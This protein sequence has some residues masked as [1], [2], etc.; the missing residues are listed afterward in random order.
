MTII[1][2]ETFADVY[3]DL[4][5]SLLHDYDCITAPRDQ[6]IKELLNC[7]VVIDNP[8][9]NL[10]TNSHRSIPLKYL[11]NELKLYLSGRNDAQGFIDASAFWGKIANDDGT[12][13]SAYGYLIFNSRNKHGFSQYEWANM[14]LLKDKDSRQAI[15]HFNLPEHQYEGNKDFP[16]T[17]TGIFNI[18]DDKLNLTINIRSNDVRKGVQFDI[19]FFTLLQ[20]IMC[21][22][23]KKRYPNLTI[24]T[25]THIANSMHIY[26]ADFDLAQA[27]IDGTFTPGGIPLAGSDDIIMSPVYYKGLSDMDNFDQHINKDFYTWIQSI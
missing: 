17:L 11:K 12:I 2:G 3:K 19:P 26:E 13:N 5:Q 7:I 8:H 10:F 20:H 4:L 22:N 15:I 27:M 6:K 24:G 23:L 21:Q 16:C 1:R 18:R 14:S 25:Y 9:S